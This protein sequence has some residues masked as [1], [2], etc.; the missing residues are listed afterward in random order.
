LGVFPS[1]ALHAQS[2]TTVLADVMVQ[3]GRLEQKQFDAPASV[4]AIDEDTIRN[5]GP[6]VNLS[7]VLSQVPGVVALNRNNYAQDVQISIRG[8]GA[9]SAFGVRGIRIITDG[10][11]ATIPDGQGQTSTV[12]MTSTER[13]EVLTGPLAQL[14]GNSSGGVIQTFTR[15][16]GDQPEARTQVMMGSFGM[17]RTDWQ[18]SQ[19]TGNVGLVADYS[20]FGIDGYRQN[21]D[22]R[23]QQLNSVITVDAQ[24]DTRFKF[25]VNVLDMPY[26]KDPVGLTA[27]QANSTPSIAGNL[28]SENGAQK[29]VK[30][31]QIGMVVD[32]KLEGDLR[33]QGRLYS[34]MRDTL[35]YQAG[36]LNPVSPAP[37]K[38]T[39]VGLARH[40]DG[41]GLQLKG[42]GLLT[43][44]Q[45][46]DW[47]IGFD[48]DHSGEQR[49]GGATQS[50]SKSGALTRNEWNEANNSDYYGQFNWHLGERWTLTTGARSSEVTLNS[51]NY[52]TGGSSNT[53]QVTYK[54]TSPVIG[55][56]WHAQDNLNLYVNQGKGFET[57]TLSETAY[58]N[59]ANPSAGG[60]NLQASKSEH[61]EVGGKW[62]ASP[63]SR[64]D[65]A[66][67]R[68]KTD[69][70]IAVDVAGPPASYKN[71]GKTLREGL[72]LS[73]RNLLSSNWRTVA[74]VNVIHAT[75]EDGFNGLAG[76]NLPGIPARQLFTSVQ[77]SEKGFSN[78]AKKPALGTEMSIDWMARSKIW[79]TDQNTPGTEAPGF[80]VLNARARQRYQIGTARLE[81]FVGI[82]NLTNRDTIGSV[83]INQNKFQYFEP[84]LP[85]SWVVG[86]QSQ[87]PL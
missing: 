59:A 87:I 38:A 56:T 11:P 28:S 40:F 69:N 6:Q 22:T 29:T 33:F 62:L 20:T 50:G 47:V 60:F 86:L 63:N 10:I 71:V 14:Y 37:Y 64:L 78:N 76:K 65:L 26:A 70:E 72:E 12:S 67:F 34:G 18:F 19:K 1:A 21:S 27:L 32:H 58:T 46:F 49:Q 36:T 41:F 16:S 82:D 54:A 4:Y 79:A 25:I 55:L 2:A 9:R 81:A 44:S 61:F 48:K 5:S 66:W 74:S 83:I 68:I 3:S 43:Q 75:Y 15:E 51:Q 53:G 52:L 39:W 30:H 7:D 23:R 42:K 57:P 31:E 77:W 45:P 24:P 8:F 13:I 84:G 17:T 73:N 85:R 80:G 35:Q